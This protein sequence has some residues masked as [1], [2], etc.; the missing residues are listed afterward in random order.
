MVHRDASVK[1]IGMYTSASQVLLPGGVPPEHA[2]LAQNASKMP[3]RFHAVRRLLSNT[4]LRLLNGAF[5]INPEVT[6]KSV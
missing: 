4:W 6:L 5:C 1:Y 3:W 2:I